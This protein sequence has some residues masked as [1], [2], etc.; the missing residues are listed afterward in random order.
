MR[1]KAI[2]IYT[3]LISA[4]LFAGC[5]ADG[6]G[7]FYTVSKEVKL[8][9]SDLSGLLI[10]SFASDGTDYYAGAGPSIWKASGSS[11]INITPD[12]MGAEATV[13]SDGTDIFAPL[14]AE[15][16]TT[17]EKSLWKYNA[18]TWSAVD[19]SPT[20]TTMMILDTD[21]L[22]FVVISND[23]STYS[24]YSTIDFSLL[25]PIPN[26]SALSYPVFDAAYDGTA[27]YVI[28]GGDKAT[29]IAYSGNGAD[30]NPAPGLPSTGLGGVTVDG[31]SNFYITSKDGSVYVSANG[32][33]WTIVNTAPDNYSGDTP[34]LFDLEVVDVG[35][36]D[37]LVIGA[38][39]GYYEMALPGSTITR[40]SATIAT[41]IDIESSYATLAEG[42]VR[43]FYAVGLDRFFMGT[44]TG[45]WENINGT[46]D[47]K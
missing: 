25:T 27:N 40:P 12:G 44:S 4:L 29:T 13:A 3:V 18:G 43:N 32:S 7:I 5:N 37:Y 46:L 38:D 26:M 20:G 14:Y 47:Q 41:G 15:S 45:V 9:G 39:E 2:L 30:M 31:L 23:N 42:Y 22:D 33:A 16:D 28:V 36:S 19:S 35:G 24:V 6:V 17:R 21:G 11:W 1:T 10:R 34:E 8:S